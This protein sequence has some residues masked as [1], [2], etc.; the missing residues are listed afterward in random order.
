MFTTLNIT[1][2]GISKDLTVR[3]SNRKNLTGEIK[4]KSLRY[5]F[6]WYPPLSQNRNFIS[7]ISPIRLN[8][9]D[10]DNNVLNSELHLV[11]DTIVIDGYKT[12]IRQ[13]NGE[14]IVVEAAMKENTGYA[15]G[16][17]FKTSSG[18]DIFN[19]QQKIE[20]ISN[21]YLV[22]DFWGSWCAPCIAA[23]PDLVSFKK[24]H[25]GKVDLISIVFDE[26]NNIELAKK[27][28]KEKNLTWPQIWDDKSN[29]SLI[30]IMKIEFFP[31]LIV[32]NKEKKVVFI[33]SE[34][35]DLN[36]FFEKVE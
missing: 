3:F 14:H 12:I 31:T 19:S 15:V 5:V 22:V 6:S 36:K 1:T 17:T 13:Y 21:R 33:T 32:V 2:P 28:I 35:K 27:I 4:M 8:V 23:M 7:S 18:F 24:T 29:P 9:I 25:K 26:K 34:I 10:V 11:G 30:K 16:Q 20:I